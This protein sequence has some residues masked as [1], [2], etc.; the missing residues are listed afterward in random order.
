MNVPEWYD[1]IPG[2]NKRRKIRSGV[3]E[4]FGPQDQRRVVLWV[5]N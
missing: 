5:V 2:R 1:T 3:G 4:D